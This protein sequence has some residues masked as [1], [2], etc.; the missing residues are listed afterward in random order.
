MK[1]KRKKFFYI[2][3]SILFLFLFSSHSALAQ[4]GQQKAV[5]GDLEK[6]VLGQ[7]EA[8]AKKTQL[9]SQDPRYVVANIIK[10]VLSTIGI[11][12]IILIIMAGYWRITAH[13]QEEK[14]QKSNKTIMGAIIGL[15][16]VMLAYAITYFIG[17]RVSNVTQ[18]GTVYD[19]EDPNFP[20]SQW[21]API[22][23]SGQQ[24]SPFD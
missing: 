9:Q 17:T 11:F 13:G 8:G 5:Q 23:Y 4:A 1:H 16:V 15:A 22:F 12:F 6:D 14:I 20:K 3:L 24:P 21:S 7:L 18:E 19:V 2:F 10:I